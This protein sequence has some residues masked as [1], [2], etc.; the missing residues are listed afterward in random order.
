[1]PST[2]DAYMTPTIICEYV[3][4]HFEFSGF[5][6]NGA[7]VRY[8]ET[9]YSKELRFAIKLLTS[10]KYRK[11]ILEF[12]VRAHESIGYSLRVMAPAEQQKALD[13]FEFAMKFRWPEFQRTKTTNLDICPTVFLTK[14]WSRMIDIS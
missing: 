1:M 6:G 8:N 13:R 7:L 3:G 9:D 5:D 4:G 14:D 2:N 12:G 10:L 11:L